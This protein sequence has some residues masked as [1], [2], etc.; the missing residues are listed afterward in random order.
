[1]HR[2]GWSSRKCNDSFV[3]DRPGSFVRSQLR[4]ISARP[5]GCMRGAVA[6]MK[7]RRLRR[8]KDGQC[9]ASETRSREAY[10]IG[11]GRRC[12]L[13]RNYNSRPYRPTKHVFPA[14][15]QITMN[16]IIGYAVWKG[17]MFW[18][19]RDIPTHCCQYWWVGSGWVMVLPVFAQAPTIWKAEN[20]RTVSTVRILTFRPTYHTELMTLC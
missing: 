5:L 11:C 9:T 16:M 2:R 4:G 15:T 19:T 12:R 18:S 7:R 8:R 3:R 10:N 6:Y 14:S 17:T 13:A 1:M 20:L